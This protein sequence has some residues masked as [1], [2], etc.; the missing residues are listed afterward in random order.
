M[1]IYV[2]F[3]KKLI[4][5]IIYIFM[6]KLYL[7]LNVSVHMYVWIILQTPNFYMSQI[8]FFFFFIELMDGMGDP[9]WATLMMQNFV[10]LK[11]YQTNNWCI[12]PPIK[13][14]EILRTNHLNGGGV[15]GEVCTPKW[16]QTSVPHRSSTRKNYTL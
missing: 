13:G 10:K 3:F 14:L 1:T 9:I 11:W 7:T 12:F 16:K 15:K 4:W 8:F 2:Y 6:I 5:L